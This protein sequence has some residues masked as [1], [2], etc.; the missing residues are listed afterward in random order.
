MT[1]VWTFTFSESVENHKGMQILGNIADSGFTDTELTEIQKNCKASG[2]D[3]ELIFL[4]KNLPQGEETDKAC[5]LVIKNALKKILDEKSCNLFKKEIDKL[6]TIVDKKA[7][8][9]G[10]IV[11]KNARYNLCFSDENQEPDYLNKKGR[12]VSF[13]EVPYLKKVREALPVLIGPKASKM[14]AELNYYYDINK[15]GIGFHG[16]TERKRVIGL[17]IGASMDLHYCWYKSNK[18][19][20]TRERITLNDGDI[21]IMSEKAVGFDWKKSSIPTLRHAT[22]C[23]KFIA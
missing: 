23:E 15:C 12:I 11:N 2:Y 20:G 16:D 4:N 8:M 1:K 10:R 19:I 7:Y 14:F 13:N 3:T 21:Y 6:E 17:R 9:Y 22:G 5:V 18:R